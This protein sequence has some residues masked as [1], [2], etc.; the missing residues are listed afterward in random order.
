MSK[1]SMNF[2]ALQVYRELLEN[3]SECQKVDNMPVKLP[4]AEV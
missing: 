2:D 1:E 4:F 3:V